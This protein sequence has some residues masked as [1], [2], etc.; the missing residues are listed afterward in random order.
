V[1][2]SSAASSVPPGQQQISLRH[3]GLVEAHHHDANADA[4]GA[5]NRSRSPGFCPP[6]KCRR[7]RDP[8]GA[9]GARFITAPP[10]CTLSPMVG[11]AWLTIVQIGWSG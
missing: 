5:A 8:E 4:E 11:P 10:I 3:V 1:S 2:S 7:R 6:H 9:A